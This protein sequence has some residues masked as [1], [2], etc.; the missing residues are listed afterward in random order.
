MQVLMGQLSLVD[1]ELS[2]SNKEFGY[3]S[4]HD[5]GPKGTLSK[6]LVEYYMEHGTEL[7]A[8]DDSQVCK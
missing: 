8:M 4:D 1:P 6:P 2:T 5:D 7:R 3:Y